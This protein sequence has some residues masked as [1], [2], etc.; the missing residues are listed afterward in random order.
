[1]YVFKYIGIQWIVYIFFICISNNLLVNC[2]CSLRQTMSKQRSASQYRW[3]A[4]RRKVQKFIETAD[5]SAQSLHMEET[6][7]CD[8]S[9]STES[10]DGN[11]SHEMNIFQVHPYPTVEASSSEVHRNVMRPT[12]DFELKE[13]SWKH[14]DDE[15]T[16]FQPSESD[17]ED[18]DV[19]SDSN[20]RQCLADWACTH[21]VTHA[22]LSDLLKILKLQDLDVPLTAASLLKTPRSVR[23]EQKSG[24]DYIYF[25]LAKSVSKKLA[26]V[27]YD[28]QQSKNEIELH[29]NIDGLPLFKSSPLSVWPILCSF[30]YNMQLGQK[31]FPVALFCGLKKPGDLEFLSDFIAESKALSSDGFDYNKTRLFVKIVGIVC[32]APAKAFIKGIVQFNGTYGCDRCTHKGEYS[33]GRMLFLR[34][35]AVLRTDESFRHQENAEHHKQRSPFCD[36]SLDISA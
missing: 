35:D 7:P 29:V 2:S 8:L 11:N 5:I 3:L 34:T 23:I 21:N 36:L 20:I 10:V 27:S 4:C 31:P 32:D 13:D 22:A 16:C 12:M 17:S 26:D 25:G 33:E 24:G 18:V 19:S 28:L 15:E 30:S 9:D 14:G 1:M 6:V